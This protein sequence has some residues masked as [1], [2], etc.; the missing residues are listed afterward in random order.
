MANR[1]L[2][3][4]YTIA[5]FKTPGSKMLPDCNTPPRSAA[6]SAAGVD[7]YRPPY[8]NDPEHDQV[9]PFIEQVEAD[10]IEAWEGGVGAEEPE[11]DA[12]KVTCSVLHI[13]SWQAD[14]TDQRRSS[15]LLAEVERKLDAFYVGMTED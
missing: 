5:D 2:G 6:D 9:K 7:E 10:V 1:R 12:Q 14:R 8:G 3:V 11:V 13:P 15:G 4:E